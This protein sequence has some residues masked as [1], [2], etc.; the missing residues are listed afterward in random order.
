M[1]ES[2]EA[3]TSDASHMVIVAHQDDDI[4]FMNRDIEAALSRGEALTTVFVTAG[5][6]GRNAAYWLARED[7]VRAAY[8]SYTGSADWINETATLTDG[9]SSF[10][11][12]TSY[13]ADH[14][15]MRLYFLRL[16]DGFRNGTGSTRYGNESLQQ[17][18]DSQIDQVHTVDGTSTYTRT[19]LTQ[20]LQML[21]EQHQPTHIMAHD[22]ISA[23][24]Q[25]EHSDHRYASLFATLAH[26]DYAAD[27]EFVAYIGYGS[28]Q[29]PENLTDPDLLQ[30]Y[31]DAF[32]A[33]GA[34]DPLVQAGTDPDG[35]P[36]FGT[37]YY[38][39][40]QREYLV[41]DVM[42]V[43]SLDF[44]YSS[45]WR[46]EKHVREVADADGDGRADVVGFG[47]RGVFVAPAEAYLFGSGMQ[48][49]SDF[50]PATAWRVVRHAREMGDVN[51]DGR[52]DIIAFGDD[53]AT[54]ALSDGS[55]FVDAGLWVADFGYM[56]GGWRNERH[57]RAI[58][59]VDGDG[60]DDIVGFGQHG[61]LVGLSNG[62]S[63]DP[64]QSW[65]RDFA[66]SSGWRIAQHERALG[67]VNG[68]GMADLVGFHD[69]GVI[70]ALSDG[71][72]F[73]NGG[74]WSEDF[75]SLDDGW[76]NDR[77]VRSV[78]DVNGDGLD[79][80]VG[81]GEDG[82]HVA[83]AS[84]GEFLPAE[85]WSDGFGYDDGW[86][87]DLHERRLADI[88]GD[89]MADIVGFGDYGTIV[90]LSNGSGFEA[91]GYPDEFLF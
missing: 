33:Y 25:T 77:H 74:L 48:W 40:M 54:V 39:W 71:S 41:A 62:D 66:Q 44:D 45:G 49:S 79:D 68:D 55:G 76:S 4:L 60:L 3:A 72:S 51:G 30:R 80:L 11:V 26:Q 28:Q 19:E 46:T 69:Y 87:V 37:T 36:I 70:I 81:F 59:D 16:P 83:L 63:F 27:H 61:V 75:G 89:G 82:V 47:Q 13:L 10:T 12:A 24:A 22:H 88:N 56:A 6:A 29:L 15:E 52:A 58:G 2:A 35:N 23:F 86:R 42:D 17:L 64:A 50:T 9:T 18:W 21:M 65:L 90:A 7:G 57:T 32:E 67:D 43:W 1:P 20:V 31:Y 14:P 34:H 38:T 53:G 91:P 85:L 5:D 73:T 78:A 8:S 84:D